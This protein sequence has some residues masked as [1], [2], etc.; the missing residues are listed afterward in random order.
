MDMILKLRRI[1][2][3]L[4]FAVRHVLVNIT[5]IIIVFLFICF[6]VEVIL[7][8]KAKTKLIVTKH[9]AV[10]YAERIADR[11]SLCDINAYVAQNWNKIEEDLNT[12][13]QRSKFLYSS[14][15]GRSS[16]K[17]ANIYIIGTWILFL[18]IHDCKIITLYK[19]DFGVGD[20][21]NKAFVDRVCKRLEEHTLQLE[22]AKKTIEAEKK[23]YLQIIKDNSAH[24][25]EYKTAIRN[26]EKINADYEDI[27]SKMDAR[28]F[29]SEDLIKNDI[30]TLILRKYF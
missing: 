1:N 27:V 3:I 20:E 29:S 17:P 30:D 10:R 13:Y 26:L 15:F 6:Y 24:I 2:S 4:F 9:A 23:A 19:I 8:S 22:E 25:N 5:H 18:D 16:D 7:L 14:N 11:E 28:L 21:F 12:M